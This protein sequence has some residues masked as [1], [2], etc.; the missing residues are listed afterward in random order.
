M[1]RSPR[2]LL[3]GVVAGAPD[4]PQVLDDREARHADVDVL[5]HVS[6]VVLVPPVHERL[7]GLVEEREHLLRRVDRPDRERR[8]VPRQLHEVDV[9][10]LAVRLDHLEDAG[11]V[12]RAVGARLL[13]VP[14]LGCGGGRSCGS[15]RRGCAQHVWM[16]ALGAGRSAALNSSGS[17]LHARR[18]IG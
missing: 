3:G 1:H 9:E 7:G 14:A 11:L 16:H 10:G 2:V 17:G 13:L 12:H 6:A 18:V 8:R 15:G 5:V 4:V